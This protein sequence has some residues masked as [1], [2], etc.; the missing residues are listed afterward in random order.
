MESISDIQDTSGAIFRRS[1]TLIIDKGDLR[2]LDDDTAR[3]RFVDKILE[4]KTMFK[5]VFLITHLEDVAEQFPNRIKV[6]FDKL[7]KS[8]IIN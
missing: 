4:L 1:N 5:N 3:Q 6:G 7:G 2:T 8:K